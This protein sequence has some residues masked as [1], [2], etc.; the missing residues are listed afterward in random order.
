MRKK[1]VFVIV[2]L[3]IVLTSAMILVSCNDKSDKNNQQTDTSTIP[4]DSGIKEYEVQIDDFDL[5]S[6][7]V[8]QQEVQEGKTTLKV[9][10]TAPFSSEYSIS[11]GVDEYAEKY[12]KIDSVTLNGNLLPFDSER[13]IITERFEENR[14]CSIEIVVTADDARNVVVRIEPKSTTENVVLAAGEK[15]VYRIIPE[16]TG[17]RRF[18]VNADQNVKFVEAFETDN[19]GARVNS[20]VARGEEKGRLDIFCKQNVAKYIEI[21]N[22]SDVEREV[23]ITEEEIGELSETEVS[24]IDV[25]YTDS[26]YSIF[27]FT[28]VDDIALYA[29]EVHDSAGSVVKFAKYSDFVVYAEDGSSCVVAANN[30]NSFPQAVLKAGVYYVGFYNESGLECGTVRITKEPT[31]QNWKVGEITDGGIIPLDYKGVRVMLPVSESTRQY[32]F[33][34]LGDINNFPTDGYAIYDCKDKNGFTFDKENGVLTV[35]PD[36][37]VGNELT[38]EATCGVF[39]STYRIR[40]TIVL[41]LD[42]FEFD[43]VINYEN[44]TEFSWTEIPAVKGYEFEITYNGINSFTKKAEGVTSLDILPDLIRKKAVNATVRLKAVKI[45][46]QYV[47]VNDENVVFESLPSLDVNCLYTPENSLSGGVSEEDGRCITNALQ[48]SNIR[49][50]QSFKRSLGC[51][52][53]LAVF[54]EWTPIESLTCDIKGNGYALKN[55]SFVIGQGKPKYSNYGIVGENNA[56]ISDLHV[57][58]ISVSSAQGQ[59]Y[60]PWISVGGIAGVNKGII[61]NC[62]VT[63][64]MS[65]HRSYSQ[66]G[67]IAG[68]NVSKIENCVF[69]NMSAEKSSLDGNGDIGGIVGKSSGT[70]SYCRVENADIRQYAVHDSRSVGG[71]VGYCPSG[72]I[73]ESAVIN[74][75]MTNS[76]PDTVADIFPKMGYIVGHVSDGIIDSVGMENCDFGYG[77]LTFRTRKYCFNGDWPFYGLLENTRVDENVGQNGPC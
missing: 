51:D 43:P 70:V 61:E 48:L 12:A 6:K 38:I 66:M 21:E 57:K 37:A 65:L 58:N 9:N 72:T 62:S 11:V 15:I 5:G 64:K 60:E 71:I 76:N 2:A 19:N 17:F 54:G 32:Q 50:D 7:Y 40:A 20:I 30:S 13:K 68:E 73:K 47:S 69:G 44:K 42:G 18:Y 35:T 14:Q 26:S 49:Y 63:G 24:K 36:C 29:F 28:A 45:G 4:S 25:K 31:D 39:V 27:K 56:V 10:F 1:L 77:G 67:G 8:L 55:L 41:S 46:E 22:T 52:I 59:H 33:A 75:Y 23:R 74:L 3:L 53:D 16:T 34:F